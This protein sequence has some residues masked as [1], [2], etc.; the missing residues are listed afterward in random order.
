MG[1]P[2]V[3]PGTYLKSPFHFVRFDV[4]LC[5]NN[6]PN[7]NCNL[8]FSFGFAR[9]CLND[10]VL[11]LT[12]K[13]TR[14]YRNARATRYVLICKPTLEESTLSSCARVKVRTNAA[15]W[16]GTAMTATPSPR[17]P[18]STRWVQRFIWCRHLTKARCS[19]TKSHF[20]RWVLT[21]KYSG[22]GNLCAVTSAFFHQSKTGNSS[23]RP[24]GETLMNSKF[25]FNQKLSVK[26]EKVIIC[27]MV[28]QK[29]DGYFRASVK[30]E[31]GWHAEGRRVLPTATRTK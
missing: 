2:F 28:S 15:L 17:D 6:W 12:P 16:R 8:T 3:L 22:E 4:F 31:C 18:I 26:V 5:S 10:I 25:E 9:N 13:R 14:N 1:D 23:D 19:V 11:A 20:S 24:V 29:L 7:G 27:L 21:K 30:L